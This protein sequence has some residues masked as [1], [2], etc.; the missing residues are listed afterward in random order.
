VQGAGL[1]CEVLLLGCQAGGADFLYHHHTTV[2]TL[3][4]VCDTVVVRGAGRLTGAVACDICL[5]DGLVV[6]FC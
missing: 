1:T 6:S 3:R 4:V 5:V 2:C